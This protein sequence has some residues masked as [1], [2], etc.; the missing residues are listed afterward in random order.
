MFRPTG[1]KGEATYDLQSSR[2]VFTGVC[3]SLLL[4]FRENI[5]VASL[6]AAHFLFS[7]YDRVGRTLI[8]TLAGVVL[9]MCEVAV[10][11]QAVL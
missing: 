8:T 3:C 7:D 1:A 5:N 9:V 11:V 4:I 2:H 10:G 6:L